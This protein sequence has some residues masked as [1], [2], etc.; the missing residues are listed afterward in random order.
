M[1]RRHTYCVEEWGRV[2]VDKVMRCHEEP[3]Q[4]PSM[5]EESGRAVVEELVEMLW[6]G[7]A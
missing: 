6:H 4:G 7:C 3:W 1:R 2:M 5:V